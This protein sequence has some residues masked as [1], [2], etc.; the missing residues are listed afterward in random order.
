MIVY[1]DRAIHMHALACTQVVVSIGY[2]KSYVN[3]GQATVKCEE[4]LYGRSFIRMMQMCV[5][6][7]FI[8]YNIV[9]CLRLL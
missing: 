6:F 9:G 1:Q 4:G 8:L 2:L 3:M 5:S 7:S